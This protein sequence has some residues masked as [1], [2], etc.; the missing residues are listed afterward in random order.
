MALVDQITAL[1][2]R[3]GEVNKALITAATAA[4]TLSQSAAN[5]A[6]TALTTANA[7]SATHAQYE[8]A[9]A[10]YQAQLTRWA[11]RVTK[12]EQWAVSK[13]YVVP[14]D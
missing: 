5:A 13:G 14:E 10:G 6:A 11:D 8:A 9:L 12:L 7:A 4:S 1:A 3:C 2:K